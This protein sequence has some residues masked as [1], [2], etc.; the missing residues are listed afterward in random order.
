M[1]GENRFVEAKV[2]ALLLAALAGVVLLV[3]V[4]G[5]WGPR[6]GIRFGVDMAYTGGVPEGAPVR[7]A[8]VRVGQVK[9]VEL[10][11]DR[12]DGRGFPLPVRF[13]LVVDEKARGGLTQDAQFFVA[14]QGALGEPFVEIEPG[15]RAAA[16]IAEGGAIRGIDPGRT[17]LLISR[18]TGLLEG[19][20]AALP[21]DPQVLGSMF[22]SLE[23]L[24]SNADEALLENRTAIRDALADLAA[25]SADL[26]AVAQR[27]R[28]FAGDSRSG[29]LADAA[30]T[31]KATQRVTGA[32][33]PEDGQ[34]LHEALERYSN[35]G[36]SIES[37]TARADKLLKQM[38]LEQA[39]GKTSLKGCEDLKTT[40]SELRRSMLRMM[41]KF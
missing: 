10:L 38:E 2:S 17:D 26:T 22:N 24:A 12:R 3:F 5:Q 1:K 18:V 36:R 27:V 40:V 15:S 34:R 6:R 20:T 41:V 30:A 37:L 4:L 16:P 9:R 11:P 33:T 21:K 14:T 7:M 13:H 25:A 32:L 35:A 31:L 8:G 29:A 19:A 39:L 28:S 23:R